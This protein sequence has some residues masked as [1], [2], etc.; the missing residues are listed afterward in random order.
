VRWSQEARSLDRRALASALRTAIRAAQPAVREAAACAL[1]G[2][3][4]RDEARGLLASLL[5][6]PAASVRRTAAGLLKGRKA[7]A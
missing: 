3:L 1:F 5:Q 6:D 4:A 2:A 7:S